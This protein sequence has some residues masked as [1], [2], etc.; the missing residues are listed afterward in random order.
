MW[1]RGREGERE[2]RRAEGEARGI[3]SAEAAHAV[4]RR[5]AQPQPPPIAPWFLPARAEP[6]AHGRPGVQPPTTM[7]GDV[8]VDAMNERRREGALNNREGVEGSLPAHERL[9]VAECEVTTLSAAAPRGPFS[10]VRALE[11]DRK[12]GG[13][14]SHAR[15]QACTGSTA[16]R[17][18]YGYGSPTC[19]SRPVALEKAVQVRETDGIS[20]VGTGRSSDRQFSDRRIHQM[21]EGHKTLKGCSVSCHRYS[22]CYKG[23][24]FKASL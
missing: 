13:V 20:V 22:H 5:R 3:R 17:L 23:L 12:S 9:H 19:M 7:S 8:H 1:L 21:T 2:K 14:S 6:P 24:Q 11:R 18:T 10:N 4:G 16:T 15:Q